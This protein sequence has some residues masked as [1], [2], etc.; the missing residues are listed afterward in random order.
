MNES[1][2]TKTDRRMTGAE[3][4]Q[5]ILDATIELLDAGASLAGLSVN[6]IV[7]AAGVS[8]ATFYLHFGD[9]RALVARLA[10]TELREFQQA[11]AGFL[12]DESAGREELA[13]TVAELVRLWQAHAGVLSSLIELAEY[14]AD[15]REEWQ[16]V[17]RAIAA[18]IAPAIT[19]RNPTMSAAQ[20]LTLAEIVAWTG[21]RA[22]HQMVGRDADPAGVERVA[23]GLTEVAWRVVVP[24]SSLPT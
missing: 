3:T 8:R 19:M 15:A 18:E 9:K 22:L 11:T 24:A 17:I 2:P 23:D 21:E 12:A 13:A 5:K 14:D 7:E 1:A 10:A 16:S 4:E 6:R 20:A